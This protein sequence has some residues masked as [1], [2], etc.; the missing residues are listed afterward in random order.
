MSTFQPVAAVLATAVSLATLLTGGGRAHN[1][2]TSINP[3]SG[4]PARLVVHFKGVENTKGEL[5]AFV[6]DNP[7]SYHADDDTKA[8][9]FLAFRFVHA[10][11]VVP[12]T[13][14]V[15]EDLPAGR[16][17]VNGYHDEDGDGALD[18]MVFPFPGMPSEPYGIANNVSASL[19]KA[20]FEDALVRVRPPL[21]EITIQ[22]SSHLRKL[23]SP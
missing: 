9:D 22:L 5:L 1:D 3:Q 11:P 18:R 2:A 21:T 7:R 13:T 10:A 16:Y 4:P 12:V 8:Q 15:F 23:V 14:V 6:H 19:S 20:S 17:A